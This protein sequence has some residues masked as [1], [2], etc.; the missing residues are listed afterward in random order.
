MEYKVIHKLKARERRIGVPSSEIVVFEYLETHF[1]QI[2]SMSVLDICEDSFISQA[3]LNR[4]CKRLGFNGFSQLKYAI[5]A[6]LDT[7]K[8]KKPTYESKVRM[9]LD[10]ISYEGVEE[11][12]QYIDANTRLIICG[13]GGSELVAMY[14]SRQLLYVGIPS[15]VISEEEMLDHFKDYV[16]IMISNSG[17]VIRVNEIARIASDRGMRVLAITRRNSKLSELCD[18]GYY[19][20]VQ[21]D[22]LNAIAREQQIHMMIM[23]NDIIERLQSKFGYE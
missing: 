1:D 13:R 3:T 16:V 18:A 15:I 11:L 23:V 12:I 6:D 4:A 21:I 2:P 17:N 7:L 20:D 22:K 8:N 19:H 5:A 10:T 9:F 14:L